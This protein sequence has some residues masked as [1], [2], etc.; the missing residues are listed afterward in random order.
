MSKNTTE[1]R[2][3]R[4]NITNKKNNNYEIEY[5]ISPLDIDAILKIFINIILTPTIN[6]K[7]YSLILHNQLHEEPGM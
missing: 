7:F 4:I 1:T 2:N 3:P 5:C 6:K